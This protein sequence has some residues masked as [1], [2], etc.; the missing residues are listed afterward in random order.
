MAFFQTQSDVETRLCT[1]VDAAIRTE[2]AQQL[3]SIVLLE[4]PFPADHQELI[5]SLQRKYP[6]N[7]PRSEERLKSLVKRVVTETSE[8]Q[9]AEGRPV[10]EWTAMITFLVGWMITLRDMD[11]ENLVLLFQQLSDILQRGDRALAHP[12]KGILMLP[13]IISY[14]HIFAR[15]AVGLDK[16]PELI[17]H[18][19]A[20]SVDEEGQRESLP[21]K[22]A[23]ILRQAFTTCLNDKNVAPR[24]IKDGKP[25]G[26][27]VGIYKMANICL[28]ILLQ[29]DKPENCDFIFNLI[30]KGSP[31]IDIYPAAE[32]VTYLYYLG[33]CHFASG[34]FYGA[35]LVLAKAYEECHCD[36]AFIQ[37]RRKILVY[38]IGA[39]IILG[40]FPADVVYEKPEAKGFR[41]IFQ[42]ITKAI[43][44]GDLETFRRITSLDL[45]HPSCDFL[46]HYRMFYQIGNYCEVL[47]WR[48]LIR[49]VYLLTGA[50]GA[51]MQAAAVVDLNHLLRIFRF[52]E[53][54]AKI[55]N[56]ALAA[57]D[58]GPGRRDMGHLFNDYASTTKSTYVD[59]D[60]AGM[61]EVEPWNDEMD[62]LE[63]EKSGEVG[64]LWC[65][66]TARWRGIEGGISES[67]VG[68]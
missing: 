54:R 18:L 60:F 42:P 58:L 33:R 31:P 21:E 4:P 62:I 19:I 48:S 27:K 16:Q 41:Q 65:E 43:R 34:N 61:E 1:A 30:S 38:L 55:K 57:S 29:A 14:A 56:A 23:N 64:N 24:G 9:D 15:V 17:A 37:Q 28:K 5:G 6:A 53:A 67:M 25:D 26:K 68:D 50:Q 20:N 13:T 44:Q 66:E 22:A 52:L 36:N 10:S 11:V 49:R 12:T 51:G 8:S 7:D 40:R 63:V 3:Q 46:M 2:D 47:V 39:N 59:P 45:T 35:Q 32:R